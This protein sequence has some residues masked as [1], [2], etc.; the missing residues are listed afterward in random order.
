MNV[1]TIIQF[2]FD[3]A[4]PSKWYR[5]GDG[6]DGEIRRRFEECS[7]EAAGTLR[8]AKSHEW[9]LEPSSTL[10][11]ILILDQFPRNMYRGTK[12]A[13]A[14][15]DLAL[16]CA[17]RGVDK[18]FDLKVPMDRRSFFYSPFMHSE[19]IKVQDK[20]VRL[21]EM[22]LGNDSTLYHAKE[23]QKLIACFGRFPHRNKILGRTN[24]LAEKT[25]LETPGYSP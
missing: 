14:Y 1:E 3:E 12:G 13:F 8:R 25:F 15:D 4:G 18:G 9:E 22:R 11:L 16:A 7:T 10:A 19:D 5:G 20:C 2:W 21:C 6:F 23:H 17:S 24:T